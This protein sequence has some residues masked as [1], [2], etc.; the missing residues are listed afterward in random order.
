[1]YRR[2]WPFPFSGSF[3]TLGFFS[4]RQLREFPWL[5]LRH[6]VEARAI[7]GKSRG[8]VVFLQVP[9]LVVVL[10]GK[11]NGK[12]IWKSLSLPLSFSLSLSLSFLFSFYLSLSLS[13]SLSLSLSLVWGLRI[14]RESPRF[15][16][17]LKPFVWGSP[18]DFVLTS[19]S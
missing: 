13:F 18:A 14:W 10:K 15:S 6:G 16:I 17:L 3:P 11:P 7:V 12:G 1:M 4:L 5:G 8:F 19:C 9:F 2:L